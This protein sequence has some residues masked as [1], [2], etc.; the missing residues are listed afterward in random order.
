MEDKVSTS[1]IQ[2]LTL[3]IY[4]LFLFLFI[5]LQHTIDSKL[6]TQRESQHQFPP[7]YCNL[8]L[9]DL[10]NVFCSIIFRRVRGYLPGLPRGF[11][12]N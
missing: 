4:F 3:F 8:V 7:T 1:K 2:L 10:L 5:A 9:N 6:A 12:S 11:D